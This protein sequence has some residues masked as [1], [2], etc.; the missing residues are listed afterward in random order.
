MNNVR[1]NLSG[2]KNFRQSV[3]AQLSGGG[4]GPMRDAMHQAAARLRSWWQQRFLTN[5]RGGGDW[6]ALKPSTIRGRRSTA[7][8]KMVAARKSFKSAKAR[9]QKAIAAGTNTA[10]KRKRLEKAQENHY[11]RGAKL[12]AAEKTRQTQLDTGMGVSILR[13]TGVLFAALNPTFIDAPGQFQM[14]VDGG[15]MVGIGGPGAHPD[16]KATIA[17]IA[18]FHQAGGGHLPQ[19]TIIVQPDPGSQVVAAMRGDLQRALS[20]LAKG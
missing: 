10:A 12:V 13:D 2:L 6:P 1:L 15:V 5:S 4:S 3:A 11:A 19:R 17:D 7:K 8:N 20:K 9:L 16:G 18:G 14:D